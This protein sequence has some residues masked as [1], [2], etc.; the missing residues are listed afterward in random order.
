MDTA[1]GQSA[2]GSGGEVVNRATAWRRKLA[3][4]MSKANIYRF[5]SRKEKVVM[6]QVRPLFVCGQSNVFLQNG[7]YP[8]VV[9]SK[10]FGN[11]FHRHGWCTGQ[12][13]HCAVN[14]KHCVG[15]SYAS[16]GPKVGDYRLEQTEPTL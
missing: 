4:L 16:C 15:A 3:K 5:F 10:A 2:L 1:T 6:I 9:E 14:H 8:F 12:S 13:C 11:T 7:L